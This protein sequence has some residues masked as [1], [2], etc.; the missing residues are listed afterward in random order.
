MLQISDPPPIITY[1]GNKELLNAKSLSIVGARNASA[2]SRYFT[3]KLTEDLCKIGY[4]IVSGLARGIDTEAHKASLKTGTIG[5]LAG[6]IDYIYPLEN[7]Q[8]YEQIAEQGLLIAELKVGAVPLGQHFPQR[9]RLISGISIGTIIMEASASSGSLITAK[10]AIEQNREVFAVPGFPGDPRSTGTNKL[11]KSGAILVETVDDIINNLP[12]YNQIVEP[13]ED[14]IKTA[15]NPMDI[16]MEITN[17]MRKQIAEL[18]SISPTDMST[19]C[20]YTSF[21][22]PVIYTVILELELAGKIIRY[23]GNKVALYESYN[24]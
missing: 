12:K 21:A 19:I 2:N 6:G 4:V 11:I 8:L 20:E 9:N 13:L 22:L 3:K 16:K 18:I 15:F 17:K 1:K 10:Y 24:S 7:K 5:V 14:K 23:P